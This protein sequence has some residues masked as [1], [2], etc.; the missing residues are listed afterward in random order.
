[1]DKIRLSNCAIEAYQA[2]EDGS[3]SVRFNKHPFLLM[4]VGKRRKSLYVDFWH[5]NQH[6]QRKLGI[7]PA[8]TADE[9]LNEG[10]QM[11]REVLSGGVL[12]KTQTLSRFF[13]DLYAPMIKATN[14]SFQDDVD[15]YKNH[16]HP[17]LGTI[18]MA[19][20]RA[21]QVQK[22]LNQLTR[23]LAPATVN[24]VRALLHRMYEVAIRYDFVNT[25][26]VK[27]TERLNVDNV[28]NRILTAQ[29]EE[30]FIQ[31]CLEETSNPS[32]MALLFALLTG[33]RINNICQLKWDNVDLSNKTMLL[34]RTKSGKQQLLPFS[35]EAG[36]VLQIMQAQRVG[37][38]VF[39]KH[40]FGLVP[41]SYPR[42][43]LTRLCK[44]AGISTTG[45]LHEGREGFPSQPVTIHSL[46]KTN[47][48]RVL[49]K[50]NDIYLCKEIMG[51]SDI[52][53]TGR[54]AFYLSEQIRGAVEGMFKLPELFYAQNGA[55]KYPLQT[56]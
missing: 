28:N 29:E 43:V 25:N 19:D 7:F 5:R 42:S 55:G 40:Q 33:P 38:Y 20:I 39:S 12:P 6:Y 35:S 8:V 51:H 45:A 44:N 15:R 49:Q 54:Y 13:I 3:R 21:I 18:S 14:R 37:P 23:I 31:V 48:S 22:L 53:V 4:K 30:R 41:I 2:V 27:K 56:N 1:M 52:K 11:Y 10:Q 26:P 46:R 17:V 34:V 16:I 24:H 36:A 9:F 50:H 47:S 32:V